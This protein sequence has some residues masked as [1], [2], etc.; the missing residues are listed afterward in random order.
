M[1]VPE[2]EI[3]K[4]LNKH[5]LLA[6]LVRERAILVTVKMNEVDSEYPV[7]F[8]ATT[9]ALCNLWMRMRT[10]LRSTLWSLTL[11]DGFASKVAEATGL[12][13]NTS[14]LQLQ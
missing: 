5:R 13:R 10:K 1:N 11:T 7:N 4:R 3:A 2:R 14:R 9:T 6:N 12:S 8:E